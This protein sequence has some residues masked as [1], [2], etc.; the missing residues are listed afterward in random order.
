MPGC[1][2]AY[3]TRAQVREAVFCQEYARLF[4][5]YAAAPNMGR[6]LMD[7]FL[8]RLRHAALGVAVRAY[9]APLPVP[10]LARLLGFHAAAGSS[11]GPTPGV[12][13]AGLALPGSRQPV[14]AGKHPQQARGK[15]SRLP[16]CLYLS[17]P[18]QWI[19]SVQRI[20]CMQSSL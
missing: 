6:A 9:K 10:F 2:K 19:S 15:P 11:A 7:V 4:R 14:F 12:Q 16:L 8:D 1:S 5:L 18:V 13:A 20:S 3:F 17:P